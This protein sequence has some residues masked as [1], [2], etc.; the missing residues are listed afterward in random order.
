MLLP[1]AIDEEDYIEI[2]VLY[3]KQNHPKP[4]KHSSIKKF[5]QI[6]R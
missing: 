3:D 2:T 5:N 1:Q 6:V 4:E